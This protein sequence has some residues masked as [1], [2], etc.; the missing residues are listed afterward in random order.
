MNLSCRMH[1]SSIYEG[2]TLYDSG[3]SEGEAKWVRNSRLYHII[4][5]FLNLLMVLCLAY[6][7]WEKFESVFMGYIVFSCFALTAS[8]IY[9]RRYKSWYGH[10][11]LIYFILGIFIVINFILFGVIIMAELYPLEAAKEYRQTQ[12]TWYN[13]SLTLLFFFI[14]VLHSLAIVYLFSVRRYCE[15]R[16]LKERGG[17]K[18][19]HG[20]HILEYNPQKDDK[21]YEQNFGDVFRFN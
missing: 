14:P 19:P 7:I 20:K 9:A 18:Q 16:V 15:T 2:L 8:I 4:C 13:I 17:L 6:I 11:I 3:L 10:N 12:D 21:D 1:R 5:W